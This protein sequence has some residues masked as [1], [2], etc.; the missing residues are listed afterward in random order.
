MQAEQ[1]Q[2]DARCD[3]NRAAHERRERDDRAEP[4]E[5]GPDHGVGQGLAGAVQQVRAVGRSACRRRLRGVAD[6]QR[7]AHADAV[8]SGQ[9]PHREQQ[10]V[11]HVLADFRQAA[12]GAE[13]LVEIEDQ[14]D[15]GQPKGNSGQIAQQPSCAPP[16]G[17]DGRLVI[18]RGIAG[19]VV[20]AHRVQPSD[21]ECPWS[22][23]A[24]PPR[25]VSLAG[26]ALRVDFSAVAV[27][28]SS[29]RPRPN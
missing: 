16:G 13:P 1:H 6:D 17:G 12:I 23:G 7:T 9:Q 11:A 19:R 28:K 21:I 8:K 25:V 18:D 15:A 10:P 27:A 29:A 5:C 20:R 3:A 2:E 14:R 24:S 4:A 26:S 22:C